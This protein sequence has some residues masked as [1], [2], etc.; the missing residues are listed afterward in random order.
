[1]STKIGRRCFLSFLIG[2]AAGTALSPLPAK[3]MD[4]L[5]IWTQNWAWTPVPPDGAVSYVKSACTLCP[6]GCGISVRRVALRAIGIEGME[7]HPVNNGGVCALGLSGLQLL[8]GRPARVETPL[9]RLGERGKGEWKRISWNE[10]ISEVAIKLG[11]IRSKGQPHT[12]ACI[13]GPERGTVP[14]LLKRFLTVYGSPNFIRT[15]SIQNSY[16]LTMLLMHGARALP[17]F[18]LEHTDFILSFGSGLIEGWGSPVRMFMA[19]SAWQADKGKVVQIEPRLSNTAAKSDRWIPI[20]PGTEGALAL[21]LAHVIIKELLYNKDFVDNYSFG[22][23]D[24]TDNQDKLRKGFKRIVLDEYSPDNVAKITGIDSPVLISLARDFARASRPLAVCGRGEGKTPGDLNEFM[25]VHA[26][27]ALVGNI[28]KKGGIW[29]VPEPDYINWPEVEMDNKAEAGMQ[30]ERIDSAGS[31]EFPHTRHLLNR[32]PGII[33]AK[34]KYPI[35]VLFVAGANPRYT[36]PGSKV[37]K[38]GFDKIPFVVSFSSYMD[39]T[40]KMADLILPNH[41][42]L[43]RYEDVPALA[44]IQRPVISLAKPVIRPQFDTKHVG[45]TVI[46]MARELGGKIAGAFPWN[47]YEECLKKTLGNKW[48]RMTRNGFWSDPDF[49][50]TPLVDAFK[51]PSGKFE[52]FV[53]A[54]DSPPR[55]SPVIPEG[56]KEDYPLI[57]IPYDSMRLASGFIG[58]PPF[59]IKTV[60]DTVLRVNNVFVQVNPKTAMEKGLADRRYATLKTPKAKVR[61][62]VHLFDGIMPGIVA[63]PKGLGHTTR[64][65][66]LADKGVNFNELIGPVE[67]PVSGLDAAWGIRADL[68]RF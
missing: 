29:A 21:G 60:E 43:E 15:P 48:R 53:T 26:L 10:A 34:E 18:D 63:M 41:V 2:G 22:F 58:S 4:D 7:G 9:M 25:A 38:R 67:D 33:D 68:T 20:N 23:H 62:K 1:M 40:A 32:F 49:K 64:D 57:L 61:V 52:F 42:Y 14:D 28:N 16:E 66:F 30:K 24:W 65:E 37:V 44:G 27:N 8:Y 11:K 3:L 5:S 59:L 13:S 45:D 50:P 36:I 54:I 17:G 46:L 6:G 56:E 39:E 12:V 31:E 55:F 35:E 47:S 19:N 51:T